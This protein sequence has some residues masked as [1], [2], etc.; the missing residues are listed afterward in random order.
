MRE[1]IVYEVTVRD[2]NNE[3]ADVSEI[4]L[5]IESADPAEATSTALEN[6][7]NLNGYDLVASATVTNTY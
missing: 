7:H 2:E 6:F 1:F 4:E 5:P 3:V